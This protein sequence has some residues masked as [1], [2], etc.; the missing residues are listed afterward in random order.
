MVGRRRTQSRQ[1][2]GN[3]MMNKFKSA[4]TKAFEEA[5]IVGS[6]LPDDDNE[7]DGYIISCRMN[8]VR[9]GY[10][11]LTVYPGIDEDGEMVEL[12]KIDVNVKIEFP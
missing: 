8:Y 10:V 11:S 4:I 9:D 6:L 5:W 3:K 12:A 1:G 2:N 7:F